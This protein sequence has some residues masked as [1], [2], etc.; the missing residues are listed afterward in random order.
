M[1]IVKNIKHI[2]N[3]EIDIISLLS[4]VKTNSSNFPFNMSNKNS[5]R[6]TLERINSKNKKSNSTKKTKNKTKDSEILI[7]NYL[8]Q[9]PRLNTE[10]NE[11][12]LMKMKFS[13]DF[14][15]NKIDKVFNVNNNKSATDKK[16][17]SQCNNDNNFRKPKRTNNFEIINKYKK[18]DNTNMLNKKNNANFHFSRIIGNNV[19]LYNK[20]IIENTSNNEYNFTNTQNFSHTQSYFNQN[21]KK[22]NN[23]NQIA[24]GNSNKTKQRNNKSED[25]KKRGMV[26]NKIVKENKLKNFSGLILQMSPANMTSNKLSHIQNYFRN[27]HKYKKLMNNQ[28]AQQYNK[29]KILTTEPKEI[30][31]DN[32][33]TEDFFLKNNSNYLVVSKN[34]TQITN[35]IEKKE[36][37]KYIN[38]YFNICESGNIKKKKM[39][40]NENGDKSNNDSG[41][42]E[43]YDTYE[44]IHFYFIRKIQKGNKIKNKL[45]IK[46]S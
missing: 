40:G 14:F 16:V 19:N 24:V 11:E 4:N 21:N 3:N 7:N 32:L 8:S 15:K 44:E 9:R 31:H 45:N 27:I 42:E 25:I 13:M 10:G 43:E 22:A 46:K 39:D 33:D 35:I 41:E 34:P 12:N 26:N 38:N 29:E 37:N 6:N 5:L 28:K 17:N 20:K 36:N 18:A 2:S 23:S 30:N 1:S